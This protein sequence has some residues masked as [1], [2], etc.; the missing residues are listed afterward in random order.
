MY[1]RLIVDSVHIVAVYTQRPVSIKVHTISGMQDAKYA[2]R[3]AGGVYTGI[4]GV[5]LGYEF[6]HGVKVC[7]N[8]R[9]HTLSARGVAE[10]QNS[11]A[12]GTEPEYCKYHKLEAADTPMHA[13]KTITLEFEF[14]I[15][16]YTEFYQYLNGTAASIADVVRRQDPK[17]MTDNKQYTAFG[18]SIELSNSGA[19]P[20]TDGN[21]HAYTIDSIKHTSTLPLPWQ[22]GLIERLARMNKYILEFQTLSA[23]ASVPGLYFGVSVGHPADELAVLLGAKLFAQ[24]KFERAERHN[25]KVIHIALQSVLAKLE[26]G[27]DSLMLVGPGEAPR[28]TPQKEWIDFN[29]QRSLDT[30]AESYI[31]GVL[32]ILEIVKDPRANIDLQG[33]ANF[34]ASTRLQISTAE[35][36]EVCEYVCLAL[37]P[38]L[39]VFKWTFNAEKFETDPRGAHVCTYTPDSSRTDTLS[40]GSKMRAIAYTVVSSIIEP[41]HGIGFGETGGKIFNAFSAYDVF[42]AYVDI[43]FGR[44]GLATPPAFMTVLEDARQLDINLK[45]LQ[46]SSNVALKC[47]KVSCMEAVSD[48]KKFMFVA[49]YMLHL[50][51]HFV[52]FILTR[53]PTT[54]HARFAEYIK[55]ACA[56]VRHLNTT[57]G[58][59]TP[60]LENMP[61]TESAEDMTNFNAFKF[62]GP[63]LNIDG[64]VI[65]ND[66]L[67]LVLGTQLNIIARMRHAESQPAFEVADFQFKN[68]FRLISS[69][70]TQAAPPRESE[71]TQKPTDSV[72]T[73]TEED[74]ENWELVKSNRTKKTEKTTSKYPPANNPTHPVRSTKHP[75]RGRQH[76][77]ATNRPVTSANP[78][79]VLGPDGNGE[80]VQSG[81]DATDATTGGGQTRR[82]SYGMLGPEQWGPIAEI[83]YPTSLY[84]AMFWQHKDDESKR[85]FENLRGGGQDGD[86][87]GDIRE[88]KSK[89]VDFSDII[90]YLTSARRGLQ[91]VSMPNRGWQKVSMPEEKSGMNMEKYLKDVTKL[92]LSTLNKKDGFQVQD[93]KDWFELITKQL[94]LMHPCIQETSDFDMNCMFRCNFEQFNGNTR[95]ERDNFGVMLL[96]LYKTLDVNICINREVEDG[97]R[98]CKYVFDH[99]STGQKMTSDQFRTACFYRMNSKTADAIFKVIRTGYDL[100]P[101]AQE[102]AAAWSTSHIDHATWKRAARAYTAQTHVPSA[103]KEDGNAETEPEAEGPEKNE[104][105]AHATPE[106]VHDG[107]EVDG[108]E[109]QAHQGPEQADADTV[110]PDS[111]A[112]RASSTKKEDPVQETAVLPVHGAQKVPRAPGAQ[113]VLRAPGA[114]EKPGNKTGNKTV[115][116]KKQQRDFG[117]IEDACAEI[118]IEYTDTDVGIENGGAD[119]E[120]HTGALDAPPAR[121]YPRKSRGPPGPEGY[122]DFKSFEQLFLGNKKVNLYANFVKTLHAH[123]SVLT[124]LV[125]DNGQSGHSNS[126]AFSVPAIGSDVERVHPTA[127]FKYSEWMHGIDNKCG[128]KITSVR[129]MIFDNVRRKAVGTDKI[130]QIFASNEDIRSKTPERIC[131]YACDCEKGQDRFEV[132]LENIGQYD[133]K[134]ETKE[135]HIGTTYTRATDAALF[136]KLPQKVPDDANFERAMDNWRS[137]I[138]KKYKDATKYALFKE[139]ILKYPDFKKY[140][141][142][143]FKIYDRDCIQMKFDDG[144]SVS[145]PLDPVLVFDSYEL[146][147]DN[148]FHKV[149]VYDNGKKYVWNF[150]T[151]SWELKRETWLPRRI[152]KIVQSAGDLHKALI[153]SDIVPAARSLLDI[154]KQLRHANNIDIQKKLQQ[155]CG[156]DRKYDVKSGDLHA[157]CTQL[158]E[159]ANGQSQKIEIELGL[160]KDDPWKKIEGQMK[161]LLRMTHPCLVIIFSYEVLT[162]LR[163]RPSQDPVARVNGILGEKREED[164]IKID[165]P[166]VTINLN[167]RFNCPVS[168]LTSGKNSANNKTAI[169]KALSKM[170]GVETEN[171]KNIQYED[172]PEDTVMPNGQTIHRNFTRVRCTIAMPT[173]HRYV[174]TTDKK[175]LEGTELVRYND[176]KNKVVKWTFSD[177]EWTVPPLMENRKCARVEVTMSLILPL[178][179]TNFSKEKQEELKSK[180]ADVSVGATVKLENISEYSQERVTTD[181]IIEVDDEIANST[182]KKLSQA[183]ILR[184]CN[185]LK[186]RVMQK[187]VISKLGNFIISKPATIMVTKIDPKYVDI[188]AHYTRLENECRSGRNPKSDPFLAHLSSSYNASIEN[189]SLKMYYKKR[190]KNEYKSASAQIT[191]TKIEDNGEFGK[192]ATN[193]LNFM[194]FDYPTVMLKLSDNKSADKLTSLLLGKTDALVEQ[195]L[196]LQLQTS[197]EI[198]HLEDNGD[199]DKSLREILTKQYEDNKHNHSFLSDISNESDIFDFLQQQWLLQWNEMIV[200]HLNNDS[201][202]CKFNRW[203]THVTNFLDKLVDKHM[204]VQCNALYLYIDRTRIQRMVQTVKA[205][206]LEEIN[207]LDPTKWFDDTNKNYVTNSMIE[208][209]YFGPVSTIVRDGAS[210]I[211]TKNVDSGILRLQTRIINVS[212][213]T[214]DMASNSS[215]HVND[216]GRIKKCVRRRMDAGEYKLAVA[217]AHHVDLWLHLI[218]TT[219]HVQLY[220]LCSAEKGV[221]CVAPE[222]ANLQEYFGSLA[223]HCFK[224]WQGSTNAI[225]ETIKTRLYRSNFARENLAGLIHELDEYEKFIAENERNSTTTASFDL[226]AAIKYILEKDKVILRRDLMDALKRIMHSYVYPRCET[227]Q[228]MRIENAF[229]AATNNVC[230]LDRESA[231]DLFSES[232]TGDPIVY[233][234]MTYIRAICMLWYEIPN[235]WPEEYDRQQ[236]HVLKMMYMSEGM[237]AC[238]K[239]RIF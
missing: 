136:G 174:T 125:A 120:E 4:V 182:K 12:H 14:Q 21:F 226:G 124:N 141:T 77:V 54:S 201:D 56:H 173:N 32:E 100:Q 231:N 139:K 116:R 206:K 194:I 167:F 27:Y 193:F 95:R 45:H 145:I 165:F 211:P 179:I 6:S 157:E 64:V 36:Q 38:T 26:R 175:K 207:M 132:A 126:K 239:N 127:A 232:N 114:Q 2:Q 33:D 11:G 158:Q 192:N 151:E 87:M 209:S 98:A 67:L 121:L 1:I 183:E 186:W 60:T 78:F 130:R 75:N 149:S 97:I 122:V 34:D 152:A 190:C 41:T 90:E 72:P 19:I 203:Q 213:A 159:F 5:Y 172:K 96:D 81:T 237:T 230:S 89:G 108:A 196:S 195:C 115:S 73:P 225:L 62:D 49:R 9:M 169:K 28:S 191:L 210:D 53:V 150:K 135:M 39:T 117:Y 92:V 148:D 57:Q 8:G 20:D 229:R 178:S 61:A 51:G 65:L 68:Y 22:P 238:H 112:T 128:E 46:T 30:I 18:F 23:H 25:K 107:D 164:E 47:L 131:R 94:D 55:Y 234:H 13:P 40:D 24:H 143:N 198:K 102:S 189:Y 17:D 58:T 137:G 35:M 111:W 7:G 99:N 113:K 16:N 199:P 184:V 181:V 224:K 142:L 147:Y 223:S 29:C 197:H 160:T 103:K 154:S 71:S 82:V 215:F 185:G 37:Y 204:E 86:V 76:A 212:L 162:R 140:T 93:Q 133:F 200:V 218:L 59:Y 171:V 69:K 109:T 220:F 134:K 80:R 188:L 138:K 155:F 227:D 70:T 104:E 123:I 144:T 161:F 3:C 219:M 166:R 187:N 105:Q 110:K 228:K 10:L 170:T 101:T 66:F 83:L 180:L 217:L 216:G 15:H 146:D 85:F 153:S 44:F 91:K 221:A 74:Q 52:A 106:Q 177:L 129:S 84:D 222:S 236:L 118:E 63:G 163:G 208:P 176:P 214:A 43:S 168:E 48:D 31:L 119:I 50:L 235:F 88:R 79:V 156:R 202:A 205:L 233:G 42:R